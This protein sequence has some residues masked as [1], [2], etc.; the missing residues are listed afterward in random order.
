[1]A[2]ISTCGNGTRRI[3]FKGT[4][5][6]RKTLYLGRMSQK[7]AE[8]MKTRVEQL[9]QAVITGLMESELS[10]W[11]I[12]LDEG[13]YNRLAGVGLVKPRTTLTL[14]AFIDAFIAERE[15][16][17]KEA[18]RTVYKRVRR[19]LVGFFT[20]AKPLREIHEGD[21]DDWRLHLEGK[22]LSPN[23]I[24]RA[25]GIAKQFLRSAVRKKLIASNPFADFK[26]GVRGN[27]SRSYFVSREE[28]QSVMDACPDAQW[29]LIFAFCRFGG[30]RC[31]SEILPL[32]WTDV[33][34]A[35]NRLRVQSP[36]TEH[37]EGKGF[38][39]LPLFP[40]LRTP[41]LEVFEQA[42]A[43]T[44]YVITRYRLANV[45][46]RTQLERIIK[47]AGLTAWP[48]LFQ[49]LRSSA[50]FSRVSHFLAKPLARQR[51]NAR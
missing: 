21:G 50:K 17:S 11:V 4:D 29:R 27:E 14:G 51:L 40:E 6:N 30:L 1:M 32:K 41:L 42:A 46:L 16:T 36:K 9:L 13:T 39:W 45:N 47:N 43:G 15:A 3:Y 48:K 35:G 2:S 25:C 10:Q 7:Q 18:T 38:R 19:Y 37:H 44:E 24:R 22:G 49:N 33:D 5:G 31:P 20:E 23:T 8:R 12:G 34:W 28:S 26:G